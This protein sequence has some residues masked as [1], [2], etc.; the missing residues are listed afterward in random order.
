MISRKRCV[1][2][3]RLAADRGIDRRISVAIEALECRRLL[4]AIAVTT[5]SDAVS[6]TGKSLRDAIA[7]ANADAL[8][9]NSDTITF[10]SNLN[11]QT[12][13]LAQGEL[14]LGQGGAG[15]GVITI[16]GSNQITV[17]GNN[18]TRVLEVDPNVTAVF[19]GLTITAGSA[20]SGDDDGGG[21]ENAGVLTINNS[22]F[23]SDSASYGGGAV[24][25]DAS[26]TMTVSNSSFSGNSAPYEGG[27]IDSQGTLTVTG[28][29]FSTNSS[30]IGDGQQYSTGAGGGIDSAGALT[31][32]NSMFSMNSGGFGGGISSEGPLTVSDSTFSSNSSTYG[33]G[34]GIYTSTDIGSSPTNTATVTN[35]TFSGNSGEFP[36]GGIL[37]GGGSLTVSNSTFI[38]NTQIG[39]GQEGGGGISNGG[40]LTLMSTIVAGN[41]N[42]PDIDNGAD[43]AYGTIESD[44]TDNVIGDG[45]GLT[46]IT[47]GTNGNQIGTSASPIN[48]D[49]APL[50]YNNGGATQTM[51][52]LTG[53]PAINV[54]GPVSSLT[55]TIT[56]S[57]TSIPVSVASAIAST[58]GS[59]VIEIDSEQMLV[60]NVDTSGNNLTVTRGY[61]GTVAAA[62][63]SGAGVILAA[64]QNGTPRSGVVD[65][66]AYQL[67]APAPGSL[68]TTLNRSGEQTLAA[69][70]NVTI[71]AEAIQPD[72]KIVVAGGID[73]TGSGRGEDTYVARYNADGSLDSTF[74]PLDV[75]YHSVDDNANAVLVLPNGNILLAGETAGGIGGGD[76]SFAIVNSD[77]S[78]NTEWS[79]N[80]SGNGTDGALSMALQPD[81]KVV[82]A[83]VA[84]AANNG[85]A[86]L[87]QIGV[88]RMNPQTASGQ[89]MTLDTG[90]GSG[91]F[92]AFAPAP[93]VL[94]EATSVAIQPNGN[95]VVGAQDG[96]DE[97]VVAR[98]LGTN[99][100]LDPNFG[101]GGIARIPLSGQQ[102]LINALAIQPDGRIV[103]G[104]Q[105][106]TAG[107]E[108]DGDWNFLAARL[109]SNGLLDTS[110]N[111]PGSSFAAGA[112]FES[113]DVSGNTDDQ[114]YGLALQS[115]GKIVLS[116]VTNNPAIYQT[117]CAMRL[118]SD[119]SRDTAFGPYGSGFAE[120]PFPND[121][122]AFGSA[123]VALDGD[124]RIVIVGSVSPIGGGTQDGA[125]A[126][127]D[128]G[129][130][131]FPGSPLPITSPIQ[132]E[133]FDNGGPQIA[134]VDTTEN[135]ND[136]GGSYQSNYRPGS[137]VDL[138]TDTDGGNDVHVGYIHPGE[139][140]QFTISVPSAG[141]YN[142]EA[143]VAD[144]YGNGMF[145]FSFDNAAAQP[146]VTIPNTGGFLSFQTID[147][148]TV[149]LSA[150]THIV[151]V[152][153]D[154]TDAGGTYV[155]NLNW[156]QLIQPVATT[157][158]LTKS[159]TA[160]IK[161]GQSVTFTATVAPATASSLTP[162]GVV[163][164]RDGSTLLGD[165]TLTGGVATLATTTLP[166]GK[167]SI[168][169]D[170]E[171]G[172][173][174]FN[175]STSNT[176]TQTVTQASTTTTLSKSTTGAITY[177]QSVTLTAKLAVVSPG[178]GTPTGT[179][180]FEDGST[181]LGTG[182]V[183]GGIATLT[184]TTIPAGSNSIKALYSG[185]TN[186]TASTSG[187][188]TQTV[189]QAATST[190]LTKT[191]TA[192]IT[193]GQSVTFTA[194][195]AVVSPGAGTPTGTVS[196]MD[197]TSVLG[198]ATV[199]GG[200]ATLT[201]TT[202]PAGSN[203][204]KA[205]YSG[206]TNFTTSTSGSLSQTVN[207]A[208]TTTKLTKSSTTVLKYGQSVTFTA[209][210]AAV[211]PGA[212]M[213]TGIVT[214]K[215]GS[216][217]IGTGTLG[218]GIATFTTTT[219][220]VG[221]NSITAVYG[222]DTNFTT[223]TSGAMTQTVNQSS[224]TTKLT[225]NTTGAITSG[226]SVTFTA[227]LA[228][229]SPGA[230]TPTGTV[231]FMDNGSSI[232]VVTLSGGVAM[233]TTT[234]LPVGSN[235]ITAVSSGDTHFTASTSNTLTQTVNA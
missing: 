154:S 9:G 31:V 214:F 73:A 213:P 158:T 187:S 218:G 94:G 111:D 170:Y 60:T 83:G 16:N 27:G 101:S 77:G 146:E 143:R 150:G 117:L 53:S 139:Y 14:E 167:N 28:S 122:A 97:L 149:S 171:G 103:V 44:S 212:G 99:G 93:G 156:F 202:I 184:T 160:S 71:N 126:R 136:A 219:L 41:F 72:G 50:A 235:S 21:I 105:V 195:L 232:G 192:A 29:T 18:A 220:P 132:A 35:S 116:G 91:G 12:I 62:H 19:T 123:P 145:H 82:V 197:G 231:N 45:D 181:A 186:F 6:H 230:G 55:S 180:T 198:T 144:A 56:S 2:L 40:T 191:T 109:L 217:T 216:T 85:L 63:I 24:E 201:T 121:T 175:T 47:N 119:G 34:G 59:Y 130:Y 137:G 229:V 233:L 84:N 179:V 106:R 190:T 155:G 51:A 52:L 30:T 7:T 13:T 107:G 17:S 225:K 200:V 64:D 209:T 98:L 112:G 25:N 185:D 193:Y 67:P 222:G 205:V 70:S 11:G 178:A 152:T 189:H 23:S 37:N 161:Y 90:F 131:A 228:A 169:A 96:N 173:P 54:G 133:D 151:R 86:S 20:E 199:I 208:S 165:S 168:T 76:M 147:A 221:S 172:D 162:G 38:G 166:V 87:G 153:F 206:D 78:L 26:G 46:A 110:A 223:S 65:V 104:G 148:G 196:F 215:D 75:D 80:F 4:T 8:A 211:S 120:A 125:L 15:S 61:N 115:D 89:A 22:T 100:A 194:K 188:L 1:A 227:T 36:G 204:I 102:A 68:D 207:K 95:I 234:T 159:T 129:E 33:G 108:T 32:S 81:G 203:T 157:T 5:T 58:P 174:R 134:Y 79:Y 57:A 141:T 176:L 10:A 138:E 3:Q 74:T 43:E 163:S 69:G 140:L 210:L 114:A 127:L 183:S 224:T 142:L 118:N 113:L 92:Q 66:G 42:G 135:I 48:P 39:D 182:A 88:L 164:F 177:G 128:P 49:A 226:Q 124:G